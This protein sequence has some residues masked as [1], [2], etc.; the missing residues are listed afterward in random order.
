M[1]IGL[2]GYMQYRAHIIV[3]YLLLTGQQGCSS[4]HTHYV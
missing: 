1:V 3:H 2:V 4:W